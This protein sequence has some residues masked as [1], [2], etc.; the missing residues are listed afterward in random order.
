MRSHSGIESTSIAP[1]AQ[2]V[3]LSL[4]STTVLILTACGGG[5]SNSYNTTSSAAAA[6]NSSSSSSGGSG[7]S[8]SSSSSGASAT[9]SINEWTWVSG[10]NQINSIGVYGTLGM[11]ASGNAPGAHQAGVSWVDA[12][13]NL[14]LFGGFAIDGS[15]DH[16]LNNDLWKY[17]PATGQWTWVN[18]SNLAGSA[19]V[20]GTLG[21]AAATNVPGARENA[22]SWVDASGNLW[23]FG[24]QG[25]DSNGLQGA[26]NDLWRYSPASNMWT[27]M[28]GSNLNDQPE[29]DAG[30]GST[31]PSN[32][33]GAR[34]S[35]SSWA[36]K[37]GN[38]WLFG[39]V[40]MFRGQQ[41]TNPTSTL[42]DLWKFNI[43]S[44]Q[45]T[46]VNYTLVNNGSGP[47]SYGTQGKP[48]AGNVPPARNG[49]V[50]WI[51][52]AGNLWLFGGMQQLPFGFSPTDYNDLWQ[53]NP[54]LNQWTW[55]AGSQTPNVYGTYGTQG[56]GSAATVPG[57][58]DS[59]V[60]W[61]DATGDLWLFGGEGLD[62]SGSDP[63]G[64]LNDLWKFNPTTNQWTWVSGAASTASFG[65]YGT[66][67]AAA[68]TNIPGSRAFAHSWIDPSG[69]LW[70]FGGQG[71]P[72][73]QT[74]GLNA[75]R[76]A[77]L[78]DLWMYTP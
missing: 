16:G 72:A 22:V 3:R 29:L 32:V 27:W 4:L 52:A 19:G 74:S 53:F 15:N 5:S 9:V 35:S 70:L 12:A 56:V 78:S 30:V 77:G 42:N 34:G 25:L 41:D 2:H 13:G 58:R 50:T 75:S 43:A 37:A 49:A 18:G 54:T 57:A 69:H 46:L 71:L 24:G 7:S 64:N 67:G 21:A 45:W 14:W 11:P 33:P 44:G 31:G 8:S 40:G 6:S 73:A 76:S 48:D 59:S 68:A 60:S 55:V 61:I 10:S 23:M 51:D 65:V 20:Y 36:D 63:M 47:G 1:T 17:T 26:L 28:S 39:G 66:L 38:L 62:G